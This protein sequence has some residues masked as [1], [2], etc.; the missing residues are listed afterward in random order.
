MLNDNEPCTHS[1]EVKAHSSDFVSDHKLRTSSNFVFSCHRKTASSEN[2]YVIW[3]RIYN[4]SRKCLS[5]S[6]YL[7]FEILTT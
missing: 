5:G 1:H 7:L 4:I 2:R 6:L 3:L